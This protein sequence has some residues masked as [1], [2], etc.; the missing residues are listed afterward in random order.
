MLNSPFF[1]ELLLACTQLWA[2]KVGTSEHK[3]VC[4]VL[5]LS[6]FFDVGCWML[7][8]LKRDPLE[9]DCGVRNEGCQC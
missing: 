2:G 4:T 8:V 1:L 9:R 3:V 7:D 5:E 6:V